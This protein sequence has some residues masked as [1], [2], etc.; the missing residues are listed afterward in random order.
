MFKIAEFKAAQ[1]AL[2]KQVTAVEEL[3]NDPELKRELEFDAELEDLLSKYSMS[4]DK[5]YAFMHGQQMAIKAAEKSSAPKGKAHVGKMKRW[6]NPHSGDV[7]DSGRRDH[8][9]IKGWIEQFG[10]KTV[11]TWAKPI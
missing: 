9:T 10:L 4:K 3:R 1:L 2:A 8:L 5:L 6:T 11:L 7:V